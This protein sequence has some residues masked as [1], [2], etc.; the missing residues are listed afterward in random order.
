MTHNNRSLSR[1]HTSVFA[2]IAVLAAAIGAAGGYATYTNLTAELGR[3]ETAIG[4]VAAGEGVTLVLA[5]VLV[6]V[7]MLGQTSPAPVRIGL[8]AAPVAA[9]AAGVVVSDTLV[10][11]AVYAMTPL[12]MCISGEGLGLIA[13][14]IV[15]HHT[16]RDADTEQRN[17]RRVQRLAWH[18]AR[19]RNHPDRWARWTSERAA[20]RIARRIGTGDTTLGSTLTTVQRTRLSVGAD[21]AL[22]AMYGGAAPA[23]EL[24]MS[25]TEPKAQPEPVQLR[26]IGP[27]AH[28]TEP[29]P[30]HTASPQA[31]NHE[32]KAHPTEPFGF[33]ATPT[34]SQRRAAAVRR[35][36]GLL[37]E[38]PK[39]TSGQVVEQL[40]VS[41]ATAKRYLR[42]AR[43]TAS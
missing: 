3:S 5:L 35:V 12:A 23:L 10:E 20:W 8:W 2:A 22:A 7:T 1:T 27:T 26:L 18:Q 4:I 24:T 36:A 37:A 17:A 16:G 31:S 25:A 32:P 28:L 15:V 33:T 6:A 39:I 29:A 30:E 42:E 14:R 38:D 11:A 40:G 13:K 41:P 9:S 21:T 19:A 43:N 34:P